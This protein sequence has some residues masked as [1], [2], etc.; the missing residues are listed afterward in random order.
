MEERHES[1]HA[2]IRDDVE[3]HLGLL[4]NLEVTRENLHKIGFPSVLEG[5]DED[6]LLDV[7]IGY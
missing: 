3:M 2:N 4:R 6:R 7:L 1:D 5:L